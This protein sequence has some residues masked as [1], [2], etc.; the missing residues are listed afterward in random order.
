LGGKGPFGL[1]VALGDPSALTGKMWTGDRFALQANLSW[2]FRHEWLGVTV[3]YLY[4]HLDVVPAL[5]H[6]EITVPLYVGLG[7]AF[8]SDVHADVDKDPALG[9]RVPLGVALMWRDWPVEVFLEIAPY[10]FVLPEIHFDLGGVLGA[11]WYF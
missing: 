5:G 1:G 10:L 7:G 6:G 3:D 2:S 9:A 8:F 11:R 4:H